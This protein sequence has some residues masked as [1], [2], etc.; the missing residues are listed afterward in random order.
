MQSK[1][2]ISGKTRKELKKQLSLYKILLDRSHFYNDIDTVYGGGMDE[3]EM[4]QHITKL[5][6]DIQR[7]E[8]QLKEVI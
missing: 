5:K 2:K 3:N 6:D 1:Y 8:N 7:I 4:E